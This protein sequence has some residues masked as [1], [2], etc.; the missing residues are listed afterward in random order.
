MGRGG[1]ERE[2]EEKVIHFIVILFFQSGI[3]SVLSTKITLCFPYLSV[4]S[5]ALIMCAK[6]RLLCHYSHKH[7]GPNRPR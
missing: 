1:G 7:T 3:H 4:R 6:M 5:S 2:R